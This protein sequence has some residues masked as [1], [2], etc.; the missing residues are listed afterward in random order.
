MAA[1][2]SATGGQPKPAEPDQGRGG[3]GGVGGLS[4]RKASHNLIVS[5]AQIQTR[6]PT[7]V[8][9]MRQI[10]PSAKPQRLLAV[11]VLEPH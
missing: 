7:A 1:S 11:E 8:Q 5:A 6:T 9:S 4:P 10:P 2:S 3:G